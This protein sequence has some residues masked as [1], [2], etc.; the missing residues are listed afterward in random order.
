[1]LSR[2]ATFGALFRRLLSRTRRF[3][4][5]LLIVLVVRAIVLRLGLEVLSIIVIVVSLASLV[6]SP[7][8]S[9]LVPLNAPLKALVNVLLCLVDEDVEAC[10]V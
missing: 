8:S 3:P 4:A 1:M 7:L 2:R 6:S 5:A 10:I 9:L